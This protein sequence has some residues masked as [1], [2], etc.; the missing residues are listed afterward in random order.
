MRNTKKNREIRK[1]FMIDIKTECE[2]VYGKKIG[3]NASKFDWDLR[4]MPQPNYGENWAYVSWNDFDCMID[5]IR[6]YGTCYYVGKKPTIGT[7]GRTCDDFVKVSEKE[8][9]AL[10]TIKYENLES[11]KNLMD[12]ENG[13]NAKER[14]NAEMKSKMSRMA[15]DFDGEITIKEIKEQFGKEYY[16]NDKKSMIS[17]HKRIDSKYYN[18]VPEFTIKIK[19]ARKDYD[20]NGWYM[21][22]YNK[23]EFDEAMKHAVKTIVVPEDLI[24]YALSFGVTI[25]ANKKNEY[26]LRYSYNGTN[27]R[28]YTAYKAIL[29]SNATEIGI[30]KAIKTFGEK[31]ANRIN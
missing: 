30:K 12:W 1:N 23:A 22:V 13:V 26:E 29:P 25:N 3:T 18:N 5:A 19:P 24:K 9:K 7:V 4:F 16:V 2:K 10:K 8:L 11:V 31:R 17:F 28:W 21:C 6:T 15:L 14:K 27:D 20:E